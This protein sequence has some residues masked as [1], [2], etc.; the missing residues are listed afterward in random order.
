M[1]ENSALD[2][3]RTLVA[4][5]T[6]SATFNYANGRPNVSATELRQ[7]YEQSQ[8]V[9]SPFQ[10]L[11]PYW[12][13]W[14][15]AEVLQ[16]V[17]S[18]LIDCLEGLLPSHCKQG[19]LPFLPGFRFGYKDSVSSE[20]IADRLVLGAALQGVDPSVARLQS[21]IDGGP[22]RFSQLF[23]LLGLRVSLPLAVSKG[24]RL[25]ALPEDSKQLLRELPRAISERIWGDPSKEYLPGA[26]VLVIDQKIEPVFP[27]S[28]QIP[29]GKSPFEIPFASM[30]IDHLDNLL[31]CLS[32]SCDCPISRSYSW[33]KTDTSTSI[34]LGQDISTG[35]SY[36]ASFPR[37]TVHE[38][39]QDHINHADMLLPKTLNASD[40]LQVAMN[41]WVKCK[42][43][44]GPDCLVDM[45]VVLEALY[46]VESGS[47][48]FAFRVATNGAWHLGTDEEERVNYYE[49]F[50]KLYRE[51]SALL[52]GRKSK[53]SQ[54][55]IKDL[56]DGCLRATRKGILKLLE[57]G[58][59]DWT[60]LRL[61]EGQ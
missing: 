19:K 35:L 9:T 13:I 56:L 11:P 39:T 33:V 49:M 18:R 61:G 12:F 45:R 29:V 17:K 54:G 58:A 44:Y 8:N 30:P 21:W 52:H 22:M 28:Q 26:T 24:V 4:E 57:E 38:T 37:M 10:S 48:E 43:G 46:G 6:E 23:V 40:S 47:G 14:A 51:A 15:K 34:L 16:T 60:R 50:Y 1:L 31:L 7:L 3:L 41:R 25:E 32:L 53:S 5:S 20:E 2:E 27:D 59:P 36:R 55:E 42:L